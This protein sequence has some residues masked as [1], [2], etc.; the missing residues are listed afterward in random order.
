MKFCLRC[1]TPSP[2]SGGRRAVHLQPMAL[3]RGLVTFRIVEIAEG[4]VDRAQAI[5]STGD[6][7]ARLRRVPLVHPVI[8]A[9]AALVLVGQDAVV[10]DAEG[11]GLEAL[12]GLRD[13]LDIGHAERRLDQ[14]LDAGLLRAL[15]I[16]LD[17]RD[18]HVDRIDVLRHA[19][20]RD[21]HDVETRTV[22][23]HVDDVAIA[24]MRVEAVPS[25]L[26]SPWRRDQ[27]R[28]N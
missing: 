8:V 9:V 3:R 10:G 6:H 20:L 12:R 1:T 5:G 21:Q 16:L 11:H 28:C 2:A 14:D 26:I 23:E 4:A 25:F 15:L 22:L 27:R 13:R 19:D 17:L 18:Q 24:I 7:H